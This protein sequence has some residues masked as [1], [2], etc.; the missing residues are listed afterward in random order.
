MKPQ[1]VL[2][3]VY[4]VGDSAMTDSKDCSVYLIDVG[5]LVLIDTGAGMST[6]RIIANIESFSLNPAH[7]STIILTHCH[8]DHV[9]GALSLRQRFNAKTVMHEKEAAIVERGD[10]KMTAAHWYGINFKPLPI[11]LKLKGEE[12]RLS[13]GNYAITCLHTPGHSPGSISAYID[14]DGQ[15]VLFGQ[16]IH[17][18]FLKE[19]GAD[20]VAW[21]RSMELLLSLNADVLCEGHFGVYRPASAVHD[22]IERYLDEYGVE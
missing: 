6:D 17:G 18:P 11:D 4:M 15:R 9:G 14:I 13:F 3:R 19:F 8:I 7:I 21:T 5:D 1:I 20:M 10:A 22:Y 2:D 16:D 12:E